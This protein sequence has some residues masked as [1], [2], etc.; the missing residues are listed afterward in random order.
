MAAEGAGRVA[1]PLTLVLEAGSDYTPD[2]PLQWLPM[3]RRR[4]GEQVWVPA[5]FVG[6]APDDL[7]GDK[8]PGGW[9]T[10]PISNGQGAHFD[11]EAATAHALLE[12]L[13][14]DGNATTFRSMDAGVVIDLDGLSDPD[15]LALLKRL[16]DAGI[17]V[18]VKLAAQEFGTV[19]VYAVGC[20]RA[21]DELLPIMATA[22]GEAAHPDR[23]VAIR[24]ALHE[25]VAA[26]SRKAL[27]HGPL[28]VIARATP[29]GYVERWLAGHQPDRLA[30]E[31]RATRAML[32]WSAMSTTE[33]TTLLRPTVLSQRHHRRAG[34]PAH[35]GGHRR[36]RSRRR[37]AG[38]DGRAHRRPPL[39]RGRPAGQGG[40]AGPGGGDH[41]LR[42][43][44]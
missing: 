16:D 19:D 5:E 10:T 8:P 2:R 20:S 36:H 41:V 44:R 14:R 12:L 29:S 1:D 15:S 25:F 43:H 32:D 4:D 33:L 24:K 22:C 39:G 23:E 18:L 30:A 26:R 6:S 42:A 28:D 17:E 13:Q 31:N 11:V 37:P 40:G 38:R 9:L 21:G 35:L 7:P 27:M 3:T 34:H